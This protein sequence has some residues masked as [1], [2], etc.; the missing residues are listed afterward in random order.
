MVG[1]TEIKAA[2]ALRAKKKMG[3]KPGHFP[4]EGIWESFWDVP[5]W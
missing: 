3:K 4:Q 1:I 5:G 2:T